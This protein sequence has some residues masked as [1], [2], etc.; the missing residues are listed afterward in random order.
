[1][2]KNYRFFIVFLLL[3]ILLSNSVYAS[4][5]KLPNP[6]H[7]FY[8]YDE[9]DIID[10]DVKNY[11]IGVN[12]S[13]SKKTGAQVVVAVMNSL[14]NED[15]SIEEFANRLFEKW[16]I[17][18]EEYDNGVLILVVPN[19]RKIWIEVG[20]GLEGALPDG[21]VGE[22]MDECIVP[23]FK[24]DNYNEGILRG[25]NAIINVIEDEYGV[26]ID[27]E[28]IDEDLYYD[29]DEADSIFDSIG[30][31]I[32]VAAILIFLFVD[33]RFFDGWVFYSIFRRG[34]YGGGYGR[35]NHNDHHNSGGGGSSGGGGAGRS[36]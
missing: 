16:Q 27:R 10:Y 8:I 25:F 21:K 9:M 11:I 19:D 23:Y 34:R 31:M 12:E 30:S 5:F 33:S 20:Y 13:M 3:F 15:M 2:R 22:I 4:D 26:N 6:S 14:E 32:V 36:W 1:M 17:G 18:S 29:Y 24:D 35:G 7:E 28:K